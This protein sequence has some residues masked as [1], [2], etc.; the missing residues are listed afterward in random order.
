MLQLWTLKHLQEVI[1]KKFKYP[2]VYT[3]SDFC[4]IKWVENT[5]KNRSMTKKGNMR[6]VNKKNFKPYAHIQKELTYFV[7]K[8]SN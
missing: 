7:Y 3:N 1:L 4:Y 6:S 5:G 2:E 8:P